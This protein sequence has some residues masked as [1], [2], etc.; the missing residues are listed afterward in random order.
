MSGCRD[1]GLLSFVASRMTGV[2]G[3][4]RVHLPETYRLVPVKKIREIFLR[5]RY[6][7]ERERE[8]E[9]EISR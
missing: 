6:L 3:R 2:S 7:P 5:F 9:R 1:R 8:R 4:N